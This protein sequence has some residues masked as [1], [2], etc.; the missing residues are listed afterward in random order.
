MSNSLPPSTRVFSS[1]GSSASTRPFEFSLVNVFP[2][3]SNF[4]ATSLQHTINEHEIRSSVVSD[5]NG[6]NGARRER[7]ARTSI[8]TW[9][10]RAITF[11]PGMWLGKVAVCSLA[12]LSWT[13]DS[14]EEGGDKQSGGSNT[15]SRRGTDN[16]DTVREI[17]QRKSFFRRSQRKRMGTSANALVETLIDGPQR[18]RVGADLPQGG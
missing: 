17:G 13:F 16:D 9:T 15:L 8:P 11:V 6:K 14:L 10:H 7:G 18:N 12:L 3:T 5:E 2:W 1:A 4:T